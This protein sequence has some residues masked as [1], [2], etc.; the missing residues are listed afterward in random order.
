M[1]VKNEQVVYQE[2]LG[3]P[4]ME[5]RVQPPEEAPAVYA[6]CSL[7]RIQP[8][9]RQKDPSL[10]DCF[11]QEN[12][13][14]QY[15]ASCEDNGNGVIVLRVMTKPECPTASNVKEQAGKEVDIE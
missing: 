12:N 13:K 2:K 10:L 15:N 1:F 3:E 14:L 9:L 11:K 7:R 4:S 6:A 5:E 8:I